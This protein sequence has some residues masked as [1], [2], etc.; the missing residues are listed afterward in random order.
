M[1]SPADCGLTGEMTGIF[2]DNF[3]RINQNFS[4]FFVHSSAA[5][6]RN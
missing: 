2:S 1:N 6:A 5:A 4:R 3:A